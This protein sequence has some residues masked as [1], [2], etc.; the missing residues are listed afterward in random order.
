VTIGNAAAQSNGWSLSLG[1]Y[2]LRYRLASGGMASVYLAKSKGHAAFE[3]WVAVK[4]IAPQLATDRSFVKMFLDEARLVARLNHPNICAVLDFGEAEQTYF[5]TMEYLHGESLSTLVKSA[6]RRGPIPVAVGCRIVADAARGLHAAHELRLADG[7]LAN[8]VHRDVS[9]Q[10][11]FVLY[12]GVTKVVDF[13]IARSVDRTAER[14]STGMI[15]G[16]LSYMAPEQLRGVEPDRRIDVFALG[17]VLW[18]CA[19]G[20]RLFQKQTEAATMCAVLQDPIPAPSSVAP[21]IAPEFDAIVAKALARNPD[22]R[23]QTA[24]ELA[25]DL[26]RFVASRGLPIGPEEVAELMRTHFS[27]R[28]AQRE[29]LLAEGLTNAQGPAPALTPAQDEA[30]AVASAFGSRETIQPGAPEDEESP[31]PRSAVGRRPQPTETNYG[32]PP[33]FGALAT[34]SMP[35]HEA[36][37]GYPHPAPKPAPSNRAII[38]VVA[39]ALPLFG[40]ALALAASRMSAEPARRPVIVAGPSAQ[41]AAQPQP[42]A[43]PPAA[44]AQPAQPT[45]PAAPPPS[46]PVAQPPT[47]PAESARA[48]APRRRT[49]AP[50]APTTPPAAT[51]TTPPARPTGVRAATNFDTL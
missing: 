35:V 24:A 7:T 43:L 16:K 18:E 40:A 9:P 14:T 34:P 15:K 1:R 26:D 3:K 23:Y 50:S 21:G 6:L 33:A 49:S 28:I 8:V 38:A 17:I 32:V 12:D 48:S 42:A 36:P 46:Q 2:E 51:T 25:R 10:N 39:L 5:L 27:D 11:I 44:Q 22:E 4:V 13:G 37:S 31:E 29:K 41:P 45:Q 20:K 30:V 19:T 47:Q